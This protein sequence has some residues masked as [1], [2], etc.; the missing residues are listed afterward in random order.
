MC[1]IHNTIHGTVIVN[2]IEYN[3]YP[4]QSALIKA[5][6]NQWAIKLRDKGILRLSSIEYFQKLES[7]ELGDI[8]EGQGLLR[9]NGNPMNMGSVNEVY[10]WCAALPNTPLDILMRLSSNYDTIIKITDV[11]AFSKRISNA[12]KTNGLNFHTHIG[13]VTYNHG[14]N[15][16]RKQL[17]NQK[18][19]FNVFQKRNEYSHQNEF[20]LT[21]TNIASRKI[22]KNHIE[23][24]IGNCE[25]I[26]VI[27][28][29]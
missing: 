29:T 9:L 1:E 13:E 28:T 11:E 25:D 21:F 16:T 24:S 26:V 6:E 14:E 15:V 20:R 10:I 8:N 4:S 2:G 5:T 18:W 22:C 23:V 17:N 19:H 3:Q 7:D 27:E 12:L